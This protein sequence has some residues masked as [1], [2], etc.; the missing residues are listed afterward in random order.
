MAPSDGHH[1]LEEVQR[2]RDH[3]AREDVVRRDRLAVEDGVTFV[4][5]SEVNPSG[6]SSAPAPDAVEAKSDAKAEPE[7]AFAKR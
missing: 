5:K 6:A 7:K 2:V 1:D 4:G 3:S